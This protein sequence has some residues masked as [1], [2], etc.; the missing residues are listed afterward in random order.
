M[1]SLPRSYGPIET[2]E[3]EHPSTCDTEAVGCVSDA[4]SIA[5]K[6][7]CPY[8]LALWADTRGNRETLAQL[9]LDEEIATDRFLTLEDALI[10]LPDNKLE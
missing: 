1:S 7:L 2:D 4:S 6:V 10:T 9:S 3:C 5:G 8:H